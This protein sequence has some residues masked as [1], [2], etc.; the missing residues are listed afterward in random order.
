[1][2]QE[3]LA[4][5][6][7]K[8]ATTL[9]SHGFGIA[10]PFRGRQ[11]LSAGTRQLAARYLSGEI[12]RTV[13][14]AQFHLDP[15][16]MATGPTPNRH[17]AEAVRQIATQAPLRILP[18]ERHRTAAPGPG[19]PRGLSKPCGAH[20]RLVRLLRHPQPGLAEPGHQPHGTGCQV[21]S[22]LPPMAGAGACEKKVMRQSSQSKVEAACGS[23]NP[24][25]ERNR[26]T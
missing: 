10:T 5:S 26:R 19:T 15:E 1:M 14:P 4:A 25:V 20:L 24:I 23:V 12:G 6:E 3:I 13:Q 18:G 21:K 2:Q 8:A 22:A 7:K 17:Y 9:A 11:R 16:F